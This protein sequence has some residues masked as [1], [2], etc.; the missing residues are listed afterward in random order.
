MWLRRGVATT[1]TAIL[2]LERRAA[3]IGGVRPQ[4]LRAATGSSSWPGWASGRPTRLF[5]GPPRRAAVPILVAFLRQAGGDHRRVIDLFVAAWPSIGTGWRKL[6]EFRLASAERPMTRSAVRPIG[7]IV[8]D[9][10]VA[11]GSCG[12]DHRR[13]TQE[14]LRSAVERTEALSVV[15]RPQVQFPG[16]RFHPRVHHSSSTPSRSG[17]PGR[18]LSWAI[19]SLRGL[20]TRRQRKRPGRPSRSSRPSGDPS[21]AKTARSIATTSGCALYRLRATRSATLAGDQ[22]RF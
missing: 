1:P 2:A 3:L 7:R 11:T 20:N 13:I 6:E 9:P 5:S 8:L 16:R 17:Q 14:T 21:S 10:T 22:R 15:E 18:G 19:A 12:G 4:D